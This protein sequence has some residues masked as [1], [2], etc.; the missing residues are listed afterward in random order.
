MPP[1]TTPVFEELP[2]LSVIIPVYNEA[3]TIETIVSKLHDVPLPME[4]VAI[5]DASTDGSGAI[6]DRLLEDGMV[7]AVVHHEQNRGKG[8]ALR[9]GI[10]KATGDIIVV[11]DAD[12]EYDP[13][14]FGKLLSPILEGKA[15]AVFGSRFLGGGGRVLYFWHS[16]GN[17]FL[18][19]LSNMLTDLNL[20]DME[21]CY[22]MVRAPL[23]KSLVLTSNRF[24]FEPEVVARL[25]QA[26]ARIWELPIT[27]AGR[28]YEEGK[29]IGWKDGVAALIHILRYNLFPPRRR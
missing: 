4:I 12:L 1:P 3:Q 19:L 13:N 21:T 15:D 18:T 2:R 22:K 23:M 25:S 17:R 26:K 20:T 8:A 5:D 16:V 27:Y 7:D 24:G 11:Q 14:D 28:T 9:S 6:L 10:D 29:K